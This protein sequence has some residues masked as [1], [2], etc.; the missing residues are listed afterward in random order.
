ME[1]K[2]SLIEGKALGSAGFILEILKYCDLEDIILGYVSKLLVGEKPNQWSESDVKQFPK[3]GDLSLMDDYRGIA[4]S[5][6]AAK[7]ANRMIV[8]RISPKI[9]PLLRS[10]QNGFRPGKSTI[11]HILALLRLIKAVKSHNLK[12][13][14]T[15]LDFRKSFDSIH[16]GRMFRV[17]RAYDV[18]DRIVQAIGLMCDGTHACVLTL[19]GNTDY[20]EI[21][22]GVFKVTRSHPFYLP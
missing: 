6:I 9:N 22:A 13:V 8:N 20:F 21:L 15:F 7:L 17:V 3:F 19:D 11:S 4:L 1:A 2:K 14:L 5:S 16:H 18:P 12:D 10:N